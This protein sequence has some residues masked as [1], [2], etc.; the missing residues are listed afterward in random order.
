MQQHATAISPKRG[1]GR[2]LFFLPVIEGN[3]EWDT[4][5]PS[6]LTDITDRTVLSKQVRTCPFMT[7][8]TME[9]L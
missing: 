5:G 3:G 9:V 8:I 2:F 4:R 1:S 6:P 7:D